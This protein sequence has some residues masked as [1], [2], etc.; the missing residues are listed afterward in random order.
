MDQVTTPG[1]TPSAT[2]SAPRCGGGAPEAD[3]KGPYAAGPGENYCGSPHGRLETGPGGG[4]VLR[5]LEITPSGGRPGLTVGRGYVRVCR[6]P[7][8]QVRAEAVRRDER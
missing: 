5:W 1:D 6:A 4:P 8:A 7:G 3:I 2:E